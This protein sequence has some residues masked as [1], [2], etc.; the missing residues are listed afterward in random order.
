MAQRNF[1]FTGSNGACLSGRI[2]LPETPPRGWA[3]FAHCFTCGKDSLAATRVSRALALVGIGVLRFDFAGLGASEGEP[4]EFGFAN[5]IADLANA[6]Q[7]MESAGMPVTLLVGHS[8]GGAAVLLSARAISTVR[9]IAT[10]A[11]P[12]D[13]SHI[14]KSIDPA[15]VSRI[16]KD[17]SAEVSLPGRRF[18]LGRKFLNDA[19]AQALE[20]RVAGLRLPLL[21][22]HAPGDTIVGIENASRIFQAAKHPKSF[23]SLDQADHLLRE[24]VDA[25][26]AA[27]VI[28][29]WASRYLPVTE[30]EMRPLEPSEG[31]IAQET[32]RGKF[33]VAITAGSHQFLADEP[34]A[35]GGLASGPTPYELV[36]AGLAACTVMTVRLYADRVAMPL[37]KAR[38]GVRH[39]RDKDRTPPDRFT[40][41]ITLSGALEEEQREKLLSIADRCP[42][43][44]TLVRGSDVVTELFEASALAPGKGDQMAPD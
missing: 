27:M 42:V 2:E 25:D 35:I 5:D 33:Q 10:I 30:V 3:I 22:L 24:R 11:A 9:A 44:L 4:G 21:V 36:A 15:L 31:V 12:A 32:G 38:V 13:V 40:R 43:D 41:E 39:D 6:A 18:V 28:S 16:E 20:E 17:G 23:I 1:D 19:R 14:L 26:Y 29:A 7:A 34:L 8:L 37:E